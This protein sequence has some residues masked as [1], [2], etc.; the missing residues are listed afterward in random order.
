V[1][2]VN[3]GLEF[4]LAGQFGTGEVKGVGGTRNCDWF[5]TNEAVL[6]DT[7]GRY[8]TQD[9]HRVVDSSAWEGFLELLRKNRRRRPINGAIV[10]ISV[11]DL[12]LQTEEERS[13][14]AK[15]IRSRIDELM[16]KLQIRFPVYLLFTKCD[17]VSGFSEFFEDLGKDDRDQVWGVSLPNAPKHNDSPD[18]D[19]LQGEYD[20]LLD[21]L[22]DRVLW[23]MHNERD[24]KR[25]GAIEGFP[26]QIEN[27]RSIINGFVRQ[28]FAKNR[29]QFQPYLRGFYFSSAT[30][31]GTP[32]DRL[33]TSVASNFGFDRSVAQMPH[34]RGKSFFLARLFRDVIFPESELV[35]TNMRY[36]NFIRWAQRAAYAGM[37]LVGILLIVVWAGSV[38]R[39]EMYMGKVQGHINEYTAENARISDG[40]RDFRAVLPVLNALA[41][42]SVVYDQE[43]HPWLSGLGL[44]DPN[45]DRAAEAAYAAKLRELLLPRLLSHLEAFLRQG[46]SGGDLYSS[47]RT[48]LMFNKIE[49]LDKALVTD[50]F[51][52]NWIQQLRGEA[53]R[54]EELDQ[55]LRAL[56]DSGLTPSVLNASVVNDTRSLLLRVPVAQRVYSR[57]RNNPKYTQDV[58]LLNLLGES[59]R[60]THNI[61]PA[62]QRALSVPLLFTKEAYNSISFSAESPVISDVLNERWIFS[63]DKDAHVDFVKDDLKDISRQAKDH[64]LSEYLDVWTRALTSLKVV[65]F[66]DLNHANDVLTR[67]ADPVQSPL[68]A[69]LRLTK[70]HT[71]LTPPLLANLA[72]DKGDTKTGQLAGYLA[73]KMDSTAVDKKFRELHVLLRESKDKAAPVGAIMQNVRQLR[74]FMYELSVS[75]DP[76]KKSFE[77]ASAR[78]QSGSA[79]AI[80]NLMS[81][82]KS[83]PQPV[84]DWLTSLASQSWKVVLGGARQHV[85][86]E[87]RT[88]VYGPYRQGLAGRYPLNR[89]SS[90]ELASLDFSEFFKPGGTLDKFFQEYMKPFIETR[91]AWGNRVIDD[92]GIGFSGE[93]LT[94]LRNA[95]L[96]REAFFRENPASP[97]LTFEVRPYRMNKSDA[98]FTLEIGE[99]R[100]AYS[101]GP[102]FWSPLSWSAGDERS[103]IR[104]VFEGLDGEQYFKTYEG[105]WSWFKLLADSRVQPTES[106]N[107]YLVTFKVAETTAGSGGGSREAGRTISYEI[108]AKS[109]KNPFGSD[110]LGSIRLPG[111]I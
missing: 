21:R 60:A 98:R 55:H 49:H 23:R 4:P 9:S 69:I 50:W 44:Y 90:D 100:V 15:L 3:S 67:Y 35:G 2:L 53:T 109:V 39:H 110:T 81:Y 86:S 61:N 93:A 79:N 83:T 56:L 96:I 106:T 25:R 107:I 16:E 22:Y 6:I 34:Q 17:L 62:T 32:I 14:H 33:M 48:Y 88:Q 47:F 18:F 72:D 41:K 102:K 80:T 29:Y 10:A 94:Q 11:Q 75:P 108:R 52:A 28:T 74:D 91:G 46:H 31:D 78:Y 58:E 57:I 104:I 13:Q 65:E 66:K 77:V 70:E 84:S 59:V 73:E 89:T 103:R 43:Q 85:D 40:N 105:P 30:Q 54:R 42:A 37:V 38:T 7:A 82:A 24:I 45:V 101:H 26:Q 19:F 64:Y 51:Q 97:G 76:A 87:W 95:G 8:T 36:E 68:L 12:L 111:S 63:D 27:L 1:A 99:K 5:F 71:E 92:F 20:A